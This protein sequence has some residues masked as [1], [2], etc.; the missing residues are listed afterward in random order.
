MFFFGK[1]KQISSENKYGVEYLQ[2]SSKSFMYNKNKKGP[3]TKPWGT[4]LSDET[5]LENELIYE[6]H[7]VLSDR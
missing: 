4:S 1:S 5:S 6:T 7:C 2:T 3:K